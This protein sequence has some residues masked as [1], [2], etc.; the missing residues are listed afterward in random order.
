MEGRVGVWMELVEGRSLE[1]EVRERGDFPA[2][3]VAAIGGDLCR[4]LTAVHDAGVLHRDVK[5]QNVMRDAR[6]GRVVLM[7]FSAGRESADPGDGNA[8]L[9]GTLAGSPIYLAPEI[10]EGQRARPAAT[11]TVSVFS[12][13]GW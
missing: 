4:A 12:C 10:L 8:R 2:D 7:D 11:S 9:P 5:A 13:S 6:N 1:E 3:E